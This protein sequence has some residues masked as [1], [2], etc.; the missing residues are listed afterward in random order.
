MPKLTLVDL[1]KIVANVAYRRHQF[2]IVDKPG[3][4][5]FFLQL[6]FLAPCAHRE[7]RTLQFSRKWYISCFSTPSEVV[8]TAF[9][10][11]LTAEEHEVREAFCYKG[12]AIFGPHF[13]VDWLQLQCRNKEAQQDA[14]DHVVE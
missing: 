9:K 13:S 14:R 6:R 12:E 3:L 11:V 8:H 4:D 5:G 1:Q 2:H 10:A 7:T